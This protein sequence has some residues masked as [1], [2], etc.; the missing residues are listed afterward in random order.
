MEILTAWIPVMRKA[1]R[2]SPM[3]VTQTSSLAAG[4]QLGASA[5][6]G[7]VTVT[8]TVKI[9]QMRRT[10][11]PWPA[12]HP[13]IPVPTTPQSAC[14]LTSCVMAKMTAEMAQMRASSATNVL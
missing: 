6:R 8:V 11:R 10:V 12:G 9:T 5:K 3:F 4:T 2:V 14:P 13:H 1:A 7:C